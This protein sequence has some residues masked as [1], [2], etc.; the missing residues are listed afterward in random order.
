MEDQQFE[1]MQLIVDII[2]LQDDINKVLKL[3]L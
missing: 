3:K 1:E 2:C